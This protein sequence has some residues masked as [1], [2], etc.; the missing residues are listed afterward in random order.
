MVI[1]GDVLFIL[2]MIIDYLIIGLTAAVVKKEIGLKRR[3]FAAILGGIFSFYI[4][5]DSGLM[6]LDLAFRLCSASV[7][8]V[9][10]FGLKS[11]RK[12]LLAIIYY[13]LFAILLFGTAHIL[14]VWVSADSIKVN[15]T[16]YYIGISPLLLILLSTIIYVSLALLIRIRKG[17]QSAVA[18][19]VMIYLSGKMVSGKG[20]IDSGNK[21]T[22]ILSNSE[23]FISSNV[24]FK[25]L[26]GCDITEYFESDKDNRRCRVIP[27]QTV[28]G[29]ILLKA[30]RCDL[31][32]IKTEK[33]IYEFVQ[34]II[35]VSNKLDYDDVDII[36]PR[37]AIE[38]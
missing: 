35:A 37:H 14:S 11:I 34:P 38:G 24:V 36:I 3:L 25:R 6:I 1:Y 17:S 29:S 10:A 5:V 4:F 15:N 19:D 27:V 8:I 23:V 30:V 7:I 31:L 20:L 13:Y 26:A 32:K 12:S 22:D 33:N 18:C 2:N 16:Y 28:S 9:T 21:I